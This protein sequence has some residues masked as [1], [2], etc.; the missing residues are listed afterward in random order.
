[1]IKG[2]FHRVRVIARNST[3]NFDD[4]FS[5]ARRMRA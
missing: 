5:D 2:R 3:A 1:M 4:L